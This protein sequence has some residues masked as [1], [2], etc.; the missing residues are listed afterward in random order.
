MNIFQKLFGSKKKSPQKRKI[1]PAPKNWNKTISDLMQEMK[2]G[3]RFEVGEPETIW[4]RDYERSLIPENYR[5]PKKGDLYESKI[6]QNIDFMTHWSA[7]FTG[8]G[9]GTLHKGEQ[10]W[11]NGEPNG[12]KP[13]GTYVLPVKYI[14]LEK[15][16]V[17]EK[18]RNASDYGNF[19]FYFNTVSLNENFNLIQ[20]GFKKKPWK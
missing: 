1:S 17:P 19:Y 13:I 11:V 9:N 12:D 2:E 3:K 8:G 4:A 16:M 14:E 18:D 10:I 20:T 5:F 15:R 7:P 6:D